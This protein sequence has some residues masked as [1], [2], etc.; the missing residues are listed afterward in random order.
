MSRTSWQQL[1]LIA[2]V[3]GGPSYA[4]LAALESHGRTPLPVP[5]LMWAAFLVLAAVLLWL[6]YGVRR[7]TQGKAT[8][9]EVLR[10]ARVAVLAKACALAGA[11]FSGYFVAQLLVALRNT[12]APALRQHAL[13]SGAAAVACLV[14]VVVALVVEW[15]CSIPPQDEEKSYA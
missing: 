8:R 9:M 5:G 6:G 10:A 13:V 14:L 12:G 4:G 2:V 11:G 1:L 3:V 7:L 15:W